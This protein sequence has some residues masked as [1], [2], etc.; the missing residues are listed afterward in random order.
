MTNLDLDSCLLCS[1]YQWNDANKNEM[2]DWCWRRWPHDAMYAS[3][4]WTTKTVKQP[5]V[6]VD[7]IH[8]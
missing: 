3:W 1:G 4:S 8:Q 5:S 7:E 2:A 6:S